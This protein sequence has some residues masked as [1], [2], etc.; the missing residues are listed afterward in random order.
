MSLSGHLES[1]GF[2]CISF[3]PIINLRWYG[4]VKKNEVEIRAA[5]DEIKGKIGSCS[6]FSVN[7]D[8]DFSIL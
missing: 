8:K 1:V 3:S 5:I 2:T 6:F 7:C 4:E